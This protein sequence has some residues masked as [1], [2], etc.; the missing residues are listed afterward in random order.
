MTDKEY[1]AKCW[2]NRAYKLDMEIAALNNKKARL[3]SI[4]N[5]SVARYDA[6][7][8]QSSG[9]GVEDT[10]ITLIE[11]ISLIEQKQ[12]KL[13]RCD[14][15]TLDVIQKVKGSDEEE[16]TVLR[17]LLINRYVNRMSWKTIE[18]EMNYEKRNCMYLHLKALNAIA[19]YLPILEED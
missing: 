9:C 11:V 2:L 3:E 13:A 14:L 5:N 10:L 19:F 8:V 6:D 12:E 7:R 4:V 17:A 18:K 1:A 15:V 16:S